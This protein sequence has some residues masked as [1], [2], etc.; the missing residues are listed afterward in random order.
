MWSI[1]FA[2]TE[3][4]KESNVFTENTAGNQERSFSTKCKYEP[5]N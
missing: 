4:E 1:D 5:Y 3:T 2:G